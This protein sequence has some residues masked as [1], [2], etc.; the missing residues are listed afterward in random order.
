MYSHLPRFPLSL[1][2]ALLLLAG[3]ATA[4]TIQPRIIGGSNAGNGEYPFMVSVALGSP[5][6]SPFYNNDLAMHRCGGTLVAANWVLTAGHCVTEGGTLMAN[7]DLIVVAGVTVLNSTGFDTAAH[8][9]VDL[10]IRHPGYNDDLQ[11]DL[12]LLRLATPA[13]VD[14]LFAVDDDSLTSLLVLNDSVTA[15]GWGSTSTVTINKSATLQEVPLEF[16]PRDICN[17]ST[18]YD[19]V[20]PQHVIC[21]GYTNSVPRDTCFGDSG[22]PLLLAIGGGAWRQVGITSFG[23]EAGCAQ[24]NFPGVY[25]RVGAYDDFV[26]SAPTLPD[27]EV[28]ASTAPA[29]E[30]GANATVR[31]VLRNTSPINTAHNVVLTTAHA[32]GTFTITST[33]AG[34]FGGSCS[35]IADDN[36]ACRSV[37]LHPA[38]PPPSIFP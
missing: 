34:S 6:Y 8:H 4:A 7:G 14:P 27:I 31:F 30:F 37:R 24:A 26:T 12:A 5:Y 29:T 1:F 35:A 20:L 2:A 28:V 9:A 32:L 36:Y 22:G 17:N 10:I 3:S 18:H 23:A 38:P 13:T 15:L 16:I 21:A 33:G 11:N 19:G 25:T